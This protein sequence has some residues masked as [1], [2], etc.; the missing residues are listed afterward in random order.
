MDL[1]ALTTLTKTIYDFVKPVFTENAT[2]IIIGDLSEA[3]KGSMLN[4][5]G[6]IKH[7]FIVENEETEELKKVKDNPENE[8]YQDAFI[9][10]LKT[11]LYEN[12]ELQQELVDIV[13]TINNN[14]DIKAKSIIQ[15]SKNVNTGTIS[16]VKG[17]I[18]FGDNAK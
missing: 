14:G 9:S 6:K 12:K 3:T 7:W 8:I 5:W 11:K 18:I 1:A 2:G 16:N 13:N 10:K 4:L 17:D 15:N